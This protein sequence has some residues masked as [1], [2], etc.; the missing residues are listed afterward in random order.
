MDRLIGPMAAIPLPAA[1]ADG[2]IGASYKQLVLSQVA[3]AKKVGRYRGVPGVASVS[4]TVGDDGTLLRCEIVRKS[5]DPGLDAEAIAMIR[6]AAPFPPP[7]PGALRDFVIGLR[8]SAMP[9]APSP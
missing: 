2:E 3:K 8:F 5:V 6:R 4:F 7:P 9:D 1:S